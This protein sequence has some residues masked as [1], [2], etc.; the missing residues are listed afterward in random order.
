MLDSDKDKNSDEGFNP[1]DI[2]ESNPH[3]IKENSK[4]DV[5]WDSGTA[6]GGSGRRD[7]GSSQGRGEGQG[8]GEKDRSSGSE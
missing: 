2:I 6:T 1:D 8:K 5:N 4:P 3:K 7:D